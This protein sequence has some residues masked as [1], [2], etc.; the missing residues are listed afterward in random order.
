MTPFIFYLV[1]GYLAITGRLDIGQLVAVIAAYKELPSP[2]KDLIDWDQQR[3]DVQ[4]KYTQVVEQF[5][6]ANVLDPE[7]QKLDPEPP[8]RIEREVAATNVTHPRRV[9]R[10]AARAH[11]A[12]AGA[13]AR[14]S[15]R[16]GRS[17]SGGEYLAEAFARLHGARRRPHPGRRHADRDA[18]GFGD[19]PAHRLCRG[20]HLFPAVEPARQPDL[21]P[22]ACAAARQASKDAREERRRRFEALASG[23]TGNRRARRL[24]RLRCRRR[25]RPGG[26]ARAAA[27][28]PAD[29]RPGER[30][31]PPR[32]AQ[33][34]CRSA[35]RPSSSKPDSGGAR[36]LPRAAY[37]G[38]RPSA[39][40]RCSIPTATS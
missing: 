38:R 34:A 6:I 26:S 32:P 24:D 28:D 1:G 18:A 21:R 36:R 11:H 3:L 16:S 27:G 10:D 15:R 14:R 19:R 7:L 39:T 25:H 8:P 20:E 13:A 31:L 5:T 4:V 2:L 35:P 9:R 40:S 33:P 23:N 22:A 30:R 12:P 17:A 37:A 29:R